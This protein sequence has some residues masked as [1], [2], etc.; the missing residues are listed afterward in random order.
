MTTADLI[1][2]NASELITCGGNA[3][4]TGSALAELGI[5]RNGF[6]AAYKGKVVFIGDE[7]AFH[8]EVKPIP[9]ATVI[10]ASSRV[11]MPGFVDPH[12]HLVF[13]GTREEEFLLRLSGM[14]YR[15]IAARGGGIMS[16]VR[17]TREASEEELF[18]LGM[19]R[20]NKMLE[21]GTT[22]CEAKSGYGLS[23]D[24][25]LKILRVIKRLNEKHPVEVIPTFLGAHT[26]PAEYKNNREE[27]IE[28]IIKKM[29]P[30]VA[31]EKLASFCDVFVEQGAFTLVEGEMVLKAAKGYGLRLKVHADQLSPGVGAEFA[32]KNEAISAE[33]LEY[34]SESGIRALAENK[35][36]GVLLPTSNFFLREEKLP[37]VREMVEAGVPIALGTDFNPG[38]SPVESMQ[39][40]IYLACL[41]YG[42]SV[43]EAI[44][45]ATINAAYAIGRENE[46]GSLEPGKKADILIF[47]FKNHSHLVYHFGDNHINKVIKEGKLVIDRGG[48]ICYL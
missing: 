9:D 26:I 46:L 33:H 11:V 40:V 42:L 2:K 38:T 5:L 6:L 8:R 22:T 24:S 28:L 32:V 12:T 13:A 14:S 35:V 20:L 34:I 25:E 21:K 44:N 43:A 10:D 39:M 29:L 30:K 17:A 4:K 47:N 1:V 48:D 19:A 18:R 41:L 23:V 45:A 3:P 15:E 7:E 31:G 36:A 27:Y 37:P 16:T